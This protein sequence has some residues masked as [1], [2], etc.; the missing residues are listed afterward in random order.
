M[1]IAGWIAAAFVALGIIVYGSFAIYEGSWSLA[2]HN[3]KHS[4]ALQQ[5]NANGQASIAAN[6]WNYQTMLGQQIVN[7]IDNVYHDTTS[8][9]A[10]LKSGDTSDATAV[11]G[12]RAYDAG[13]VCYDAS[14]VNS[15]LPLENPNTAWINQNCDGGTLKPSSVYYSN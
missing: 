14:Q 10:Y 12:Q 15:A 9:A 4:L 1:R 5:Q 8:I 7:G 6:G 2:S 13:Q 3:L 11:T